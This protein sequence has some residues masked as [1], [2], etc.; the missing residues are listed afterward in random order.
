MASILAIISKKVFDK[1]CAGGKP[2][3][4]FAT[5]AYASTHKSLDPLATSPSALFLATVRTAADKTEALWLVGILED[6]KKGEAGW[7]ASPN[8]TPIVDITALRSSI[9]F[10]SGVGITDK[11]GALAMSLQTP[12][13]L[14]ADDVALLRRAVG[15]LPEPVLK[16]SP[17]GV[18]TAAKTKTPSDEALAAAPSDEDPTEPAQ[19]TALS[20]N[21]EARRYLRPR[22]P[23]DFDD[24]P[25]TRR[26]NAEAL[27]RRDGEASLEAAFLDMLAQ[28][29]RD[30]EPTAMA[31]AMILMS[32]ARRARYRE[33]AET[34]WEKGPE[35]R[36]RV[37]L[38]RCFPERAD[39]AAA[40][41][42]ER[43]AAKVRL[44]DI[45]DV[46][47][48]SLDDH[49]LLIELAKE[50]GVAAC[51]I[52]IVPTMGERAVSTI[53]AL[54]EVIRFPNEEKALSRALGSIATAAAA[55]AFSKHLRKQNVRPYATDFYAR[56]PDLAK[57]ALADIASKKTQVAEVARTILAGLERAG[58][59]G[60][61][62]DA[63]TPDEETATDEELPLILRAPPWQLGKKRRAAQKEIE[64]RDDLV[65]PLEPLKLH[66]T[67]RERLRTVARFARQV[68]VRSDDDIREKMARGE[69][70]YLSASHPA[71][72]VIEVME[73]PSSNVHV[74]NE[75]P[76]LA[77]AAHG[78]QVLKGLVTHHINSLSHAQKLRIESPRVA[79]ALAR[80]C[81]SFHWLDRGD[82]ALWLERFPEA[83][84]L[85][86][87][88]L[89]TS[90]NDGTRR[91]AEQGLRYLAKRRGVE[92]M[93]E[94]ARELGTSH[95][96]ALDELLARPDPALEIDKLPKMPSFYRVA[97]LRAPRLKNGKL[98][99]E[100]AVELLDQLLAVAN[101]DLPPEGFD[102]IR[103][104][105]EPRS[106]AEHAWDL[107]KSWDINGTKD[108][109]RW[110]LHA[111][112]HFG[113]DE[114][115]RRLTPALKGDGIA[116]MLGKIGT[117]AALMELVTILARVSRSETNSR[118]KYSWGTEAAI[119]SIAARRGVDTDE[120]E[121]YYVPTCDVG[122]GGAVKLDLGPRAFT[123][124]FDAQLRRILRD[125]RGEVARSIPRG[126]AGDDPS[127][128]AIAVTTL[129]DLD[130]DVT[131]I[132]ELRA[133]SLER[134]MLDGRS[135]SV[136]AVVSSRVGRSTGGGD[137]GAV[138]A[139]HPLMKH[140][141]RGVVWE[142]R[143]RAGARL[144]TFRIAEDG[145]F[146]NEDD[147]H[148]ELDGAAVIGV[149]HLVRLMKEEREKW[150]A[151]F[152]DYEILQP[153]DQ[154]TREPRS[155][156]PEEQKATA[157]T[158]PLPA[159][160]PKTKRTFRAGTRRV[161][162]AGWLSERSAWATPF[163]GGLL[164]FIELDGDSLRGSVLREGERVP[165]GEADPALVSEVA[166]ALE[167]LS[168]P[169]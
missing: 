164:G 68:A 104:A 92:R 169:D 95:M 39:W 61:R 40:I 106:L 30:L 77:L 12:R 58:S 168:S 11:P 2:G 108:S 25:K 20:F 66:F 94:V 109:A 9:R 38:L 157:L 29:S 93:R 83:A 26:A 13:A 7:T 151:L 69:R 73:N 118:P 6:P 156:S 119:E 112:R 53:E 54:F 102:Q 147:V 113:D 34:E 154:L 43:L 114:V 166:R 81:L 152:A 126:V 42:R 111:V 47:L 110:M 1:E 79:Q 51:V 37:R 80:R 146:A 159:L 162:R 23:S 70:C 136:E 167:L 150:R 141:A 122:Q 140:M 82:G 127:K 3:D 87:V 22:R 143:D 4:L 132:A 153:F 18:V 56:F 142:A 130:E 10:T 36:V 50:S 59:G 27:L 52:N 148:V 163:E 138:W 131:A 21:D 123:V 90:T 57:A 75:T 65:A 19:K 33:L 115:V 128:V 24:L 46:L 72:V 135:W 67:P 35:E 64:P 17:S 160:P 144:L 28:G 60:E 103:E 78:E 32:G 137:F 63:D 125:D 62:A 100:R 149:A 48:A 107:A 121:D 133:V 31:D 145:S 49:D 84:I 97:E 86:L 105:C 5:S 8:G 120:L 155:L 16:S 88:P 14:T 91:G 139:D 161:A 99:P 129:T 134:A 41:A 165:L 98:L 117:D 74:W 116:V 101:V 45:R 71:D 15:A 76:F 44:G 96:S 55:M 158:Q 89:L 85:G 124:M